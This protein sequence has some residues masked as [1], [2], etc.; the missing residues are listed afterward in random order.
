MRILNGQCD[1]FEGPLQYERFNGIFNDI[2]KDPKHRDD[3]AALGMSPDF[4]GTHS[5]RKGAA[6]H[7]ATGSTAC[8][9]IALICLRANWAMPGVLN[10][11]IKFEDAGD[12]FVGKCVS[13][14]SRKKKEFGLSPAYFDFTGCDDGEDMKAALDEWIRGQLP[15][16]AKHNE[17]VQSVFKMCLATVIQNKKYLEE[18]LHPKAS[19]V[20]LRCGATTSHTHPRFE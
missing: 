15:P 13:G 6:T 17:K 9:P 12:Q 10:R 14:R 1:L 5:L 19:S 8:P 2:I 11:Y 20:R 16:L 4:F 18:N 7:V 3:F